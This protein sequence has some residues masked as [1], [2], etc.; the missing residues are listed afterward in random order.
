MRNRLDQSSAAQSLD[1]GPSDGEPAYPQGQVEVLL[2]FDNVNVKTLTTTKVLTKR[3]MALK[4]IRPGG[5]PA[6]IILRRIV[7]RRDT[8][9]A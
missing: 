2:A 5:G 4:T 8:S 1:G 3:T 9:A 7:S 6:G